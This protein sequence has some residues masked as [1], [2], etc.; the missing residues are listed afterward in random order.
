M[1]LGG[2]MNSIIAT[3]RKIPVWIARVLIVTTIA[4]FSWQIIT[5]YET[6]AIVARISGPGEILPTIILWAKAYIPQFLVLFGVVAASAFAIHW[7][8]SSMAPKR[9]E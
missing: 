8:A 6:I 9:N 3:L 7:V 1:P 5:N 4:W 2:D